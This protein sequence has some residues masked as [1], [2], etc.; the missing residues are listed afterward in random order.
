MVCG[1]QQ[2]DQVGKASNLRL[3]GACFSS[4]HELASASFYRSS[5]WTL[6]SGIASVPSQVLG[7]V[8]VTSLTNNPTA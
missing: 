5:L 8:L 2:D 7:L 4:C 3:K 6:V 1:R